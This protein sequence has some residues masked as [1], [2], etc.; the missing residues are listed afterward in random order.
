[1]SLL[2]DLDG[3][4]RLKPQQVPKF[5]RRTRAEKK[6]IDWNNLLLNR[7]PSCGELFPQTGEGDRICTNHKGTPFKIGGFKFKQIV[8]DLE[9]HGGFDASFR[10]PQ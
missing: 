2:P 9:A 6:F 7:C 1:M 8:H 5:G 3:G 4:G 10:D